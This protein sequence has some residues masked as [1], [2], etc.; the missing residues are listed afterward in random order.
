M[1]QVIVVDLEATMLVDQP[2]EKRNIF[3]PEIIQFGLCWLELRS[4]GIVQTMEFLVRP[5]STVLG[6]FCT[7]LTGITQHDVDVGGLDFALVCAVLRGIDTHRR[8]WASWG[9]WDREVISHHCERLKVENPL[10]KKHTDIKQWHWM[11]ELQG[12]SRG[13]MGLGAALLRMDLEFEGRQ[14]TG[15]DDAHNAAKVLAAMLAKT[16]NDEEEKP[17]LSAS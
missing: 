17:T 4:L 6:D 10:G 12:R 5:T 16:H 8:P 13:G 3:E 11:S 9:T 2:E 14:H 1:Q 15:G 7:Q